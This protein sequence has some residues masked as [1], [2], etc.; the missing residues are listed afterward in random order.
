LSTIE[1][2]TTL[3]TG[4]AEENRINTTLNTQQKLT[5]ATKAQVGQSCQTTHT[6]TQSTHSILWYFLTL[7][8][9]KKE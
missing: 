2:N 6:R 9:Y 7:L 5:P 3:N 4:K 8:Q 1:L